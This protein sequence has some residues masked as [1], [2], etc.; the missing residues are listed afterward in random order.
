MKYTP[1]RITKLNPNQVLVF[2]SNTEGRHGAGLAKLALSF[3]AV[4]GNPKGLQGNTYA[5]ITK[6]L[7]KGKRSISLSNIKNQLLELYKVAKETPT[8]EFLLTRIGC[9]LAG[10]S[11]QEIGN[12][13]KSIQS[14]KPHNII[15]PKDWWL[16]N[17]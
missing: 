16:S 14:H 5:I 7:S 12:I 2:G 3:G 13:V 8:K 1:E 15:V 9:G 10:Y 17:H 11:N 4:Y 6:D